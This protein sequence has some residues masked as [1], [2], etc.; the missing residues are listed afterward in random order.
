MPSYQD[1]VVNARP[2]VKKRFA[3]VQVRL[4]TDAPAPG[5]ILM[6]V[7]PRADVASYARPRTKTLPSGR[8]LV[9]AHSCTDR[10]SCERVFVPERPCTG[11]RPASLE[12]FRTTGSLLQAPKRILARRARVTTTGR[13]R[14][15]LDSDPYSR[16]REPRPPP[17]RYERTGAER[18]KRWQTRRLR[19]P[20]SPVIS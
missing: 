3:F 12:T 15:F 5:R 7:W 6:C 16:P 19:G 14:S 13:R 10:S 11:I 18:R 17:S 8:V 9:Q 4:C 20:R 2:H 1:V